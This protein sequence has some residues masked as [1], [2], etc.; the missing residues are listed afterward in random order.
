MKTPSGELLERDKLNRANP[1]QITVRVRWQLYRYWLNQYESYLKN[2]MEDLILE[3][4]PLYKNFNKVQ[5]D[6]N[7]ALIRHQ[8]II[9]MTT[10]MAAR[11]H[12]VLKQA[13]CP[14]V[15]VEEAAEVLEAHIIPVLT[16]CNHCNI[17]RRNINNKKLLEHCQH[18]I[19]I[20]DHKQLKP[21]TSDYE[22]ETVHKL[23]VS[24]FE[25]LIENNVQFYTLNVQHRMRPEISSL[26]TPSIYPVLINHKSV[27]KFPK[28]VGMEKS[29]YFLS[30]R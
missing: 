20:G 15:I 7:L 23:G 5:E 18:L 25:R 24:M 22:I 11:M 13:K 3:Y 27:T 17:S 16:G 9:G 2:E 6:N 4:L 29:L 10:T 28:V 30:H 12:S 19:L 1:F 26:V 8:K 14:I 21:T